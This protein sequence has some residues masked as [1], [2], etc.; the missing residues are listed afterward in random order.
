[1]LNRRH[2]LLAGVALPTAAFASPAEARKHK[3][4]PKP[5]PK[6][7]W[8][9]QKITRVFAS[10]EQIT[11]PN[12]GETMGPAAPYPA[13]IHV[14]GMGRR[15]IAKVIVSLFGL[16]HTYPSDVEILLVAP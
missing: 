10:N 5:K 8:R 14:R 15:R 16:T 7:K 4:N 1:M 12:P 11:I 13:T 9:W 2:V 3:P 6:P